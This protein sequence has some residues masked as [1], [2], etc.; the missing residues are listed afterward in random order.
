MT[1]HN[2]HATVQVDGRYLAI[3]TDYKLLLQVHVVCAWLQQRLL[4]LRRLR[5]S[6]VN[7]EEQ[8]LFFM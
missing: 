6:D 8:L 3:H 5:T 2:H 4:F 7:Q 1:T